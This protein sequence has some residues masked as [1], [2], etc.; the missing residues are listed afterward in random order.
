MIRFIVFFILFL[1]FLGGFFVLNWQAIKKIPKN[2][3]YIILS[4]FL[5]LLILIII[6][7]NRDGNDY[8]SG[9][10]RP[11]YFEN[12]ILKQEKIE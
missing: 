10:Y 2:I 9:K 3:F 11:A 5:S 12:G 7:L 8:K 1:I 6:I 4:L